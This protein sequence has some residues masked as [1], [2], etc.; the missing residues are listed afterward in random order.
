MER[1]P[2]TFFLTRASAVTLAVVNAGG[3][4]VWSRALD[5][6]KGFNQY[7]WDLITERIDGQDAYFWRHSIFIRPGSYAV[8]IIGEDIDLNGDLTVEGRIEPPK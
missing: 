1:V 6:R 3:E 7:C 5:G 8:K 4:E 2:I